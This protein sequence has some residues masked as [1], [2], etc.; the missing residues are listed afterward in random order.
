MK[1]FW[2]GVVLGCIFG[3]IVADS[4]VFPAAQ[5]GSAR[6]TINLPGRTTPAPFSDAVLS[7][8]TLYLAG[9]LGLDPQTGK[10][11]ASAEQEARLVLDGI[12]ATLQQAGMSMDD[13]VQ[14]QIFCSD[15]SLYDQFNAVYRTYFKG[16]PP[17][18]A[19]LGSGALLRGARFEVMGIA[20]R[21]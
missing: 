6:R 7:G 15:L 14:V 18:R 12:R 2:S 11:P 3:V 10:P 5:T 13:L 8:N 19:F 17:A 20:V 9:R 21:R 4:V 16:E 1:G